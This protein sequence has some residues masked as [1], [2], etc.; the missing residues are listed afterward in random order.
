MVEHVSEGGPGSGRY[1]ND[2]VIRQLT[3]LQDDIR[4][5]ITIVK[6]L[7]ADQPTRYSEL[8]KRTENS[9]AKVTEIIIARR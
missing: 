8:L 2:L 1:S 3:S 9:L 4:A 7:V 5:N 6:K